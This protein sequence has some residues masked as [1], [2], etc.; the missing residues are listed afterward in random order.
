MEINNQHSQE[1]TGD[2]DAF[3]TGSRKPQ[4]YNLLS[5]LDAHANN[6]KSAL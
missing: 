6:R 1:M 5:K 2:S 4:G 3:Q